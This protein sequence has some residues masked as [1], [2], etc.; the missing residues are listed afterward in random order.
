MAPEAYAQ[1]MPFN[2]GM[3]LPVEYEKLAEGFSDPSM[4]Y[5]PFMF[6]FWDAPMNTEQLAEMAEQMIAQGIN[7]G[8]IHP[9]RSMNESPGLPAEQWLGREWFEGFEAVTRL[10]GEKKAYLGNIDEYW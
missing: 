6:W 7:P 10:S 4:I 8:Y 2:H 3:R 9:R 1:E 5:A